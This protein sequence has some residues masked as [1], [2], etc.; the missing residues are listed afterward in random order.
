[1]TIIISITEQLK[2]KMSN[3]ASTI[4]KSTINH[5]EIKNNGCFN[6]AETI[7]KWQNLLRHAYICKDKHRK[8]TLIRNITSYKN[9]AAVKGLF[10]L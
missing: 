4:C 10:S 6:N 5:T 3:A 1:M 8:F 9:I 7:E 2:S